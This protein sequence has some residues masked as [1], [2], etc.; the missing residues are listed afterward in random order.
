[1]PKIHGAQEGEL[2]QEMFYTDEAGNMMD[3]DIHNRIIFVGD[4]CQMDET[5]M[6]PIREKYRRRY[7]RRGKK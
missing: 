4:H 6:A 7:A 5:I 1:M 3:A 2:A